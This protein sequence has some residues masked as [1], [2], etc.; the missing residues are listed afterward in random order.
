MK[1]A[2]LAEARP[3]AEEVAGYVFDFVR[4]LTNV[5]ELAENEILAL[6]D[7]ELKEYLSELYDPR[8][9]A[10]LRGH[11]LL[12]EH[13][14]LWKLDKVKNGFLK[15]DLYRTLKKIGDFVR[16]EGAI[17]VDEEDGFTATMGRGRCHTDT[18]AKKQKKN[19]F[20]NKK[21]KRTIVEKVE[22][23]VLGT[24][25]YENDIEARN[26]LDRIRDKALEDQASSVLR[27][28]EAR[29][30]RILQDD[31]GGGDAISSQL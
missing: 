14:A 4:L 24:P 21:L 20:V 18:A 25:F 19:P 31:S 23:M 1:Y 17:G 11:A 6:T 7:W 28:D 3:S 12:E 10:T 13:R 15:Q 5:Y 9:A 2:S 30:N 16:F 26:L 8:N 29:M 22:S 27:R